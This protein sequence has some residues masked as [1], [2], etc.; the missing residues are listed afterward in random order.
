VP[1]GQKTDVRSCPVLTPRAILARMFGPAL[2][3]LSDDELAA[4]LKAA[5]RSGGGGIS[6]WTELEMGTVV[7]EHLV[8][9]LAVEGL[10]VVRVPEGPPLTD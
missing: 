7:A 8:N 1:F 3:P 4:V 9:R 2:E 6:R 10:R 5:L